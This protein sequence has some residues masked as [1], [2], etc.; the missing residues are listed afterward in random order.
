MLM[1]AKNIFKSLKT[2]FFQ[3]CNKRSNVWP[4]GSNNHNL[5]EIRALGTEIMATHTDGK[6]KNFVLISS[7]DIAK[8]AVAKRSCEEPTGDRIFLP[9]SYDI[10]LHGRWSMALHDTHRLHKLLYFNCSKV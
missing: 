4:R 1:K 7:A 9:H 6:R 8:L 3:K 10:V 5:K 2:S